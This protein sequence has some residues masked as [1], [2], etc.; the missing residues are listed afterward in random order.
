KASPANGFAGSTLMPIK[1]APPISLDNY[2]GQHVTRSQYRGKAV[3]VTFLYVRCT[4][5]CP[6]IASALRVVRKDLGPENSKV[7]MIAV[8]VDPHGD[9]PRSDARLLAH[10]G[11]TGKI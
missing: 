8:S 11:M 2:L 5:V 9:K 10:R 6:A 4:D 1:Q 3:F 7:R